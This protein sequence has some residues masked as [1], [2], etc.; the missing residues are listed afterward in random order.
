MGLQA[1]EL[2]DYRITG[3]GDY[4]IRL[5]EYRFMRLWNHRI[6]V[7]I[8]DFEPDFSFYLN[9]F[10][11]LSPSTL[12]IWLTPHFL[13]YLFLIFL[14][15]QTNGAEEND[16]IQEKSKLQVHEDKQAVNLDYSL[17]SLRLAA[18]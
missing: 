8:L 10:N 15:I 2:L 11:S 6:I 18:S 1:T 17:L 14:T 4:G 3:L 16:C 9:P 13:C 5:Q 12:S 7:R